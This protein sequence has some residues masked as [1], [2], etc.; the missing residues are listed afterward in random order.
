MYEAFLGFDPS[1][2]LETAQN[3]FDDGVQ[4]VSHFVQG[5]FCADLPTMERMGEAFSR[6][7]SAQALQVALSGDQCAV[8]TQSHDVDMKYFGKVYGYHGQYVQ[9]VGVVPE[10]RPGPMTYIFVKLS[11][12]AS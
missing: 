9:I 6:G 10:G 2:I 1:D 11:T 5:L 3:T 7:E 12:L 4:E 8:V